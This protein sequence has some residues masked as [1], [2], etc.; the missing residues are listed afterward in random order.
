MRPSGSYLFVVNQIF[1][2]FACFESRSLGSFDLDRFV[3][4]RIAAFASFTLTDFKRTETD[5]LDFITLG[6][7][8]ANSFEYGLY[9]LFSVLFSSIG[10]LCY[11]SD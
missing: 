7:A 3:V 4:A 1:K 2:L 10:F 8:V 6:E 9:S 11:C 5:D